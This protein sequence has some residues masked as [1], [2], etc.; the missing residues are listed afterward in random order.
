MRSEFG[1]GFLSF[2]TGIYDSLGVGWASSTLGFLSVAFIPIPFVL[3]KVD[4]ARS[5]SS[6]SLTVSD[7]KKSGCFG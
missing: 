6:L 7:A 4:L 3:Y 2:A 5:F 1:P